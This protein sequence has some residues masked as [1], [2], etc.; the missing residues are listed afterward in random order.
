MFASIVPNLVTFR[1][2][3]NNEK[4]QRR[5]S[6]NNNNNNNNPVEYNRVFTDVENALDETIATICKIVNRLS[7]RF[8]RIIGNPRMIGEKKFT[9]REMRTIRSG[10]GRATNDEMRYSKG[11]LVCCYDTRTSV[12][13]IRVT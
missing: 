2:V 4:V 5:N 8:E 1:I 10:R 13:I 6:N 3:K 9:S 7:L 11:A 12:K